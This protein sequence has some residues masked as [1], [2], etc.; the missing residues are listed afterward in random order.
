MT[1]R[2]RSD[3]QVRLLERWFFR[4]GRAFILLTLAVGIAFTVARWL[5]DPV[6]PLLAKFTGVNEDLLHI[7]GPLYLGI[8]FAFTVALGAFE[9]TGD[10]TRL[11]GKTIEMDIW[12]WEAVDRLLGLRKGAEAEQQGRMSAESSAELTSELTHLRGELES[13]LA[14]KIKDVE[15]RLRSEWRFVV[16]LIVV[17]LLAI[18]A[19]FRA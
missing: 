14:S 3:E 4:L 9:L 12:H 6:R 5:P 8:S 19:L 10:L 2:K 7:I 18:V 17:M 16:G 15:A 13:D 1:I 11:L